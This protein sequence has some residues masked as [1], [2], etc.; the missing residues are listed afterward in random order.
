MDPNLPI[1]PHLLFLWDP[2]LCSL[3]PSGNTENRE[4][5]SILCGSLDARREKEMATYSSILAWRILLTEEPGG[6]LSIGSHR[7]RHNWIDLACMHALE[8]DL[9]THSIILAWRVP[10]TE[11]PGGLLSVGSHR[12]RHDWSDLAAAAD[13]RGVWGRMDICLF[14]VESLHSSS[15]TIATVLIGY[16]PM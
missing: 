9:A 10:G 8:K 16:T 5:C 12:V 4:L 2:F 7:V 15:E 13:G 3:S 1:P 11:E 6:L 14:V